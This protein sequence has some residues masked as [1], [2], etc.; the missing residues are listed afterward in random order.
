MKTRQVFEILPERGSENLLTRKVP[1]AD[2]LLARDLHH[3][4]FI[5]LPS[6]YLCPNRANASFKMS[7]ADVSQN[8]PQ[9]DNL[10]VNNRLNVNTVD[11]TA[12]SSPNGQYPRIIPQEQQH[13]QPPSRS[14][15]ASPANGYHPNLDTQRIIQQQQQQQQQQ[16]LHQQQ[17]HHQRIQQQ[18]A[19]GGIDALQTIFGPQMQ[20]WNFTEETLQS[21]LQ[22]FRDHEDGNSY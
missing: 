15:S 19:N 2:I 17:Q 10:F 12:T 1:M 8:P 4:I 21:A 11:G 3:A 13:Q 14:C 9:L 6:V 22:V 5:T 7:T 16:Q 20:T 18:S